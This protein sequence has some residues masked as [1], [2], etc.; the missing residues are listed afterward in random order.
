MAAYVRYVYHRWSIEHENG[1][2]DAANAVIEG[3]CDAT[4]GHYGPLKS[5]PRWRRFHCPRIVQRRALLPEATFVYA[6]LATGWNATIMHLL[7][8][9]ERMAWPRS[10]GHDVH[11]YHMMCALVEWGTTCR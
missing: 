7:F 10:S 8:V 11:G 6:R 1:N 5:R 9:K 4:A 3:L 2:T